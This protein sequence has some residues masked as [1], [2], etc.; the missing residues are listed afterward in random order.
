MFL[1]LFSLS[2]CSQ[3]PATLELA[4]SDPESPKK[5]PKDLIIEEV[6]D[7]GDIEDDS[8]QEK[9]DIEKVTI[10]TIC[11]M[12]FLESIS[13]KFLLKYAFIC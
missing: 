8:S 9:K 7:A 3:A 11:A 4:L 1:F 12:I 13:Y 5:P 6:G 2:I 10:I